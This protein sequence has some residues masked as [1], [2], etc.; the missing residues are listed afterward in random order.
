LVG[1]GTAKKEGPGLVVRVQKKNRE[2]NNNE[3]EMGKR[4]G[5]EDTTTVRRNLASLCFKVD[6][7]GPLLVSSTGDAEKT[8]SVQQESDG[9]LL[10]IHRTFG[11]LSLAL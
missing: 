7:S 6:P 3:E 1:G 11:R 10:L 2:R 9:L 8:E 4:R 5:G